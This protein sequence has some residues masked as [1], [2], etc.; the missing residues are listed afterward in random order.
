MEFQQ[1]DARPRQRALASSLSRPDTSFMTPSDEERRYSDEEFAL[2]LRL[3]SEAPAGPDPAPSQPGLTLAEI[4]EIA[5]EVGIDPERVSR[6]AALLSSA[7]DTGVSRVLGGHPRH[8]L[9]QSVPGTVPEARLGRVIDVARR[10]LDTQGETREVLGALE[11]KGATNT[12]TV[13]V[14]VVPREGKTTLQAFTDRTESLAATYAGV[15]LPVT[16]VIAVTLGKLVFGETGAGIAAALL[17]GL[18][19]GMLLARTL[20]KRSTSKWRERL[21]H[22]MDA[23][24]REAEALAEVTRTGEGPG[25]HPGTGEGSS[26][27]G[28]G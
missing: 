24:V 16:V 25:P 22:L 5:G 20:W 2:I 27:V 15:G 18:P 26:G 28:A 10:A 23:M 9:E 4:R 19:P 14:S 13:S 8:R 7:R 11:W 6:A 17:S 3:S 21:L 1:G 12:T